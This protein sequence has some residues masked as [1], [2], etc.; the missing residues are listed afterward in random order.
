[1]SKRNRESE[2]SQMK[3]F[4]RVLRMVWP[5][6]KYVLIGF[7]SMIGVAAAYTFSIV[8][9]YSILG[10]L[11]DKEDVHNMVQ[12][13]V[14]Q[15]RLGV[16]LA[17]SDI[18]R[19]VRP[20][21]G[22]EGILVT[23]ISTR[24]RL[25]EKAGVRKGNYI[26]AVVT[27]SGDLQG[28]KMVRYLATLPDK[29]ETSTL[30]WLNNLIKYFKERFHK[31]NVVTQPITLKI[32]TVGKNATRTVTVEYGRLRFRYKVLLGVVNYI[33]PEPP[34]LTDKERNHHRMQML[35][36]VLAGF[37]T[38][39]IFGN[40]CR[41]LGEYFGEIVGARTL[42]DVRRVMYAKVLMLP[43]SFFVTS[44]VSDTMSR[45]MQDSQDILKA[46]RTLFGKVL[47]EP[48]KAV[49]VLVF[50]LM[51]E[52]RLTL[53]VIFIAPIAAFLFRKF[54][55]WIR[56]ANEKLLRGY[57]RLIGALESTLSGIRVVKA[58][59]MENRERKRYFR[60]ERD[61][62]KY[63]LRI[64][65]IDAMSSPLME[66]LGVLALSGGMVWVAGQIMDG[67]IKVSEL[68]TLLACMVMILDPIRKL[69][70]VYT[71]IQKANAAAKRIFELIDMQTEFE[72]SPGTKETQP[73]KSEISFTNVTFTYPN[74]DH[75]AIDAVSLNIQAGKIYAVV[76]PN[77]SGKTT[78]VSL[79]LRLFDPQSGTISWDGVDLR[80]YSL[81]S[82]RR[83]MS[84]VAQD[85]VIFADTVFNNIAYGNYNASMDEI[86]AAAKRAHA[87]EFV[88]RL[89]EGYQ[90]ILGEH[91]TS[92]SGGE[93]Q[94]LAIARAILR[95]APVLIFDE[96]T[97]QI[98][99][100]SERK[101]QE[102]IEEFLPGRTA[103]VI[104]HRFSTIKKADK[105]VV[106]DRGKITACG[107]HQELIAASPLYQTLYQTQLKGLQQ[108]E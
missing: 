52:P 63:S 14:T 84:Y 16:E 62:L 90:T 81:R 43:M 89:P 54:G 12:L 85:A 25:Y 93:R 42:I 67:Q 17:G 107:S 40:I 36:Y 69:S 82:L 2:L 75:P 45:F 94:R 80:E 18:E 37:V 19:T 97:S 101:I 78:L 88:E 47:R 96:A 72:L 98:D 41:F 83:K 70:N 7:I 61:I 65:R 59:T 9:M 32:Y 60:L 64:Q 49:G 20:M 77:G 15:N 11:V 103:L 79:L 5:H 68:L 28:W 108:D 53:L 26:A 22:E 55:K 23:G 34:N 13:A 105:I 92:L 48:L 39:S 1:M 66:V 86:I 33:P 24:D 30:S 71:D 44:G 57:G 104:A 51:L 46:L 27:P 74:S 3:Y 91:G 76:G 35:M 6:R 58:Y 8:T 50:A 10:V 99:A 102:A 4:W 95:N 21:L 38:L 106:M 100:D 29:Q 56:R 31:K 87:H 73:P